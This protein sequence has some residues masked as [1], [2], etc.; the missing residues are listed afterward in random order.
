MDSRTGIHIVL[1]PERKMFPDSWYEPDISGKA[2]ALSAGEIARTKAVLDIAMKK[3]PAH[4]LSENLEKIYLLSELEFYGVK[5]AGT[6]SDK[7]LYIANSGLDEG[8]TNRFIEQSFHHEFSSILY[9][10]YLHYFNK[11]LWTSLNP[12]ADTIYFDDLG[13][14]GAM[15]TGTDNDEFD[16]KYHEIGFLYQYATSSF[17]NDVNSFAENLFKAKPGFWDAVDKYDKIRQKTEI[18]I[19]FYNKLDTVFTEKYFRK[20]SLL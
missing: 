11:E 3:Y 10:K 1:Y 2:K 17:E 5:Y 6:Y 15:I 16:P 7:T 4:V 18:I 12:D 9:W 20:I 19:E 14:A 8:Y 13:G